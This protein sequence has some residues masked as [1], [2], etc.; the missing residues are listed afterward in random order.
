M[1]LQDAIKEIDEKLKD[2]PAADAVVVE[3]TD[4]PTPEPTEAP[5]ETPAPTEAPKE[6]APDA[7]A[8]ARMRREAAAAERRAAAA[9]AQLKAAPTQPQPGPAKVAEASANA[10]PDPNTDPEGHLRWELAQTRAQLKEVAEWKAQQTHKEQQVSLKDNAVKAFVG[11]EDAFKTTVPDYEPVMQHGLQA[12]TAS[13]RTLN[14]MIKGADLQEAVQRQVLRL[15]GQAEA[16]GHDPAEYLYHQAKSWG[17]QPKVEASA[18]KAEEK[19]AASLKNIVD[20]KKK[21]VSSFAGGKGG[22][23]PLSREAVLDKSFG[24][25]DFAKLTP[26]QLR[27]LESL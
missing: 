24:L 10:E 8:F 14:P 3:V 7:A 23:V 11:Y 9:E 17:Y 25:Q 18:A 1:S 21:S 16:Q 12:I 4:A 20:H 15:A 2:T 13:I 5:A 22:N 6:S 27:E 19:P 26:S